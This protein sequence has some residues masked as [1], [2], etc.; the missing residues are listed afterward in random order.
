VRRFF[1]SLSG[2]VAFRQTH[3]TYS[4]VVRKRIQ[5]NFLRETFATSF[6]RRTTQTLKLTPF[7]LMA[8][9]ELFIAFQLIV[10][11]SHGANSTGIKAI[12]IFIATC[13]V[14]VFLSFNSIFFLTINGPFPNFA[15]RLRGK[16]F[17]LCST[18]S[19]YTMIV[20]MVKHFDTLYSPGPGILLILLTALIIFL[21]L[22]EIRLRRLN[23]YGNTAI[24]Y[25][26]T[27]LC[28][29][30]YVLIIVTIL[31][32]YIW[33]FSATLVSALLFFMFAC[34]CQSVDPLI[35]RK[36]PVLSKRSNQ[37][38]QTDVA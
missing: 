33:S 25:F 4:N 10:E 20:A 19:P 22:Y 6:V 7:V 1:H 34:Y 3:H 21:I 16:Y 38:V 32:A 2:V 35:S 31:T 28:N 14:H 37:S 30:F 13:A 26:L 12:L 36:L 18:A 9:L 15:I 29:P 27:Y 17:R 11:H 8:L 23:D 24:R 5:E